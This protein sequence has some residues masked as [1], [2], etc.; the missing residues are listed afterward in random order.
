M[1]TRCPECQT[2]FKITVAQLKPR[3]GLVRCGRCDSVFRADLRLFAAPAPGATKDETETQISFPIQ[4]DEDSEFID[5]GE[6]AE[7]EIPVVSDLS[8]FYPP[9]R[10]LPRL[11]WLLAALPLA[12]LLLGQFAYFYRNELA[13]LP[14]LRPTLGKFCRWAR[15]ELL[16]PTSDLIPELIRTKIAP[17]PR[18][19][20]VLRIRASMVNRTEK[21]Q[22]PPLMEVSLTDSAGQLLA[23]RTFTPREYLGSRAAAAAPLSPNVVANALLDVTNPDGKATGFEIRLI[24]QERSHTK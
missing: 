20:N 5:I 21:V 6:G 22:S 11:V 4:S 3:D 14:Q 2:A 16:P 15:C 8:L 13:Q 10:G 1:Y 7:T 18:Y 9:R 24:P 17:H 12:A 23:R 19:A